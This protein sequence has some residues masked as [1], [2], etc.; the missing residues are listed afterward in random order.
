MFSYNTYIYSQY[1]NNHFGYSN[2]N[3]QDA[4]IEV[5]LLRTLTIKLRPNPLLRPPIHWVLISNF[6]CKSR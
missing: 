3:D 6:Q 5:P 2:T 1:N 4:N